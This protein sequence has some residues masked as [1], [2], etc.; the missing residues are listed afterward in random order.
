MFLLGKPRTL[1]A[2]EIALLICGLL[3][4]LLLS[5]G[6]GVFFLV[7]RRMKH[8]A[9]WNVIC[10]VSAHLVSVVR[11]SCSC[12]LSSMVL[13][14]RYSS[15]SSVKSRSVVFLDIEFPMSLM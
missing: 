4:V 8:L 6:I 11:S 3:T 15:E 7:T 5:M 9:G 13:M 12:F 1:F 14:D 10:H 2:F